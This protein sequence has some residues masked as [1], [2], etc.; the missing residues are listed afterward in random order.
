MG[1]EL[2]FCKTRRLLETEGGGGHTIT[3]VCLM[4][5]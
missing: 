1:T 2:K 5:H 4:P 3:G